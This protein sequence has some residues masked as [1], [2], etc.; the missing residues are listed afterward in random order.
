MSQGCVRANPGRWTGW[1]RVVVMGVVLTATVTT[2]VAQPVPPAPPATGHVAAPE[3]PAAP[4]PQPP[5]QTHVADAKSLLRA[6]RVDEALARLDEALQAAATE[7]PEVQASLYCMRGLAATRAGEGRRAQALEALIKSLA[8]D[9]NN[10]D[11]RLELARLQLAAKQYGDAHKNAERVAGQAGEDADMRRDADAIARRAEMMGL[12]AQG[13][14]A[15]KAR[16]ADE[17]SARLKLAL[18]KADAAGLSTEEISL[19]YYI[20]VLALRLLGDDLE[21][22]ANAQ[23]AVRL[24]PQDADSQLLLAQ[25]QFESDHYAE[26][27]AA[28]ERALLLG[29]PDGDDRGAAQS[30]IARAKTEILR[31]RLSVDVSASYG[32]DSNVLQSQR[33]VTVGSTN[34]AAKLGG[35][36]SV[37]QQRSGAT[38]LRNATQ[39]TL[40][41]L[42]RNYSET[43]RSVYQTPMDAPVQA[44]LP[45]TLTLNLSG[46][47]FHVRSL[48][49]WAGVAYFG[50][51]MTLPQYLQDPNQ[52]CKSRSGVEIA[53]TN[54]SHDAYNLQDVSVPLMLNWQPKDWLRMVLTTTGSIGLTG[55]R[56]I[57]PY[58]GGFKV[59]LSTTFIESKLLRTRIDYSHKLLRSFDSEYSYANIDQDDVSLQQELRLAFS[60]FRWRTGLGYRFRSVRSGQLTISIPFSPVASTLSTEQPVLS[61]APGTTTTAFGCFD[62]MM[63][64][65]YIGNEA[66]IYT[67]LFFPYDINFKLAFSYEYLAYARPYTA[68]FELLRPLQTMINNMMVTVPPN[69]SPT[70][71]Y[72]LAVERKDHLFTLDLLLTK[73][74]PLGFRVEAEYTYVKNKSSIA[75][76]VDNRNYD[77]HT[78]IGSVGYAF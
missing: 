76:S 58:Q 67:N 4:P 73:K 22:L 48:E 31:E 38:D 25:V 41:A 13:R 18:T 1:T 40:L 69:G 51:F 42:Y 12:L 28:A 39:E 53:C 45:V 61:C 77:K 14:E 60:H 37:T 52:V 44:D 47:L 75:I 64:L 6:D 74:L 20:R 10:S 65:G 27:R 56:D 43:I 62:Y 16:K 32:Y 26:A 78:M 7:T 11:C 34:L 57:A 19:I 35:T 17:A 54:P 8:L 2:S 71:L 36:R 5:W 66:S 30:L 46:R 50:Y 72:M 55:A 23:T 9:A 24:T 63:H 15:L 70:T 59:K 21:A 33:A 49:A 29:L 68:T 3:N